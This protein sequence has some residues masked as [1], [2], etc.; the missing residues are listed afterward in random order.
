MGIVHLRERYGLIVDTRASRND[1]L[2]YSITYVECRFLPQ[3]WAINQPIK[4]TGS[5]S[6]GYEHFLSTFLCSTHVLCWKTWRF[7]LKNLSCVWD[8]TLGQM[9][10]I[11]MSL[12]ST[13]NLFCPKVQLLGDELP[14][15][16]SWERQEIYDLVD[17]SQEFI[18]AKMALQWSNMTKY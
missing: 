13:T 6:R 7:I 10:G 11:I 17:S 1:S 15:F 3:C 16:W 4:G 9:S 14:E 8:R 5:R 12:T 2:A 18:S